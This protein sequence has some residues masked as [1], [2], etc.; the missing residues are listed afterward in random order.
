MSIFLYFYYFDLGYKGKAKYLIGVIFDPVL[1][2]FK[3]WFH[4]V[5]RNFCWYKKYYGRVVQFHENIASTIIII[6]QLIQYF[7]NKK[8]HEIAHYWPKG[9]FFSTELE[10][11]LTENH[12]HSWMF[13]NVLDLAYLGAT[14]GFRPK[15]ELYCHT[16]S[17]IWGLRILAV[18][19]TNKHGW[20]CFKNSQFSQKWPI[21][22]QYRQFGYF[23]SRIP[24]F[25]PKPFGW[26]QVTLI[27]DI[28]EHSTMY[29]IFR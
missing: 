8:F 22:S 5:S 6:N 3:F 15:F 20:N 24:K 10:P 27:Q 9:A 4:L 11:F 18:S 26:T 23:G 29:V 12:I 16:R 2:V 14:E 1:A 17:W 28:F 19:G 21:W 13:K 25:G 7:Y